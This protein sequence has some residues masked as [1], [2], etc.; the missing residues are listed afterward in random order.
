MSKTN[1]SVIDYFA[2][3]I[4]TILFK[5]RQKKNLTRFISRVLE[6][7]QGDPSNVHPDFRA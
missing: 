2:G 7:A 5:C 3:G 4:R 1:P 6:I